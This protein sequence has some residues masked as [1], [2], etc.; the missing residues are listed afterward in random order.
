[1]ASLMK[2]VTIK[3]KAKLR[4]AGR[5]RKNKMAARSTLSMDELFAEIDKA[6]GKSK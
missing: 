2:M 6:Q 3:R 5:K 4:K 1:M